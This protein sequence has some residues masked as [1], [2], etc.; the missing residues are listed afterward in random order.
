MGKKLAILFIL[1][2][3]CQTGF[4]QKNVDQ[5][6]REFSKLKDVNKVDVGSL[7]MKFAG[8]FADTFG[9][10]SIEV[11]ELGN[12][13]NDVKEQFAQTVK[14][15]K[16]SAFETLVK[17]NKNGERVK[18]LLNIHD[19]VIRELIVLSSG[20]SPAMIRIKGNIRKSDMEKVINE[21]GK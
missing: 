2:V 17:S 20:N 1:F 21:H 10:E 12:C 3:S 5:L 14:S 13:A 8:L 11:L 18:I 15:L 9:V 6:F 16:D 4:G 7:S 19:D